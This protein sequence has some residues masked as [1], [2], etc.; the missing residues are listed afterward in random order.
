VNFIHYHHHEDYPETVLAL[1]CNQ[2]N[3][4]LVKLLLQ[5]GAN[6]EYVDQDDKKAIDST[7]SEEI[8][9]ILSF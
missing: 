5:S 9:A 8:R 2:N 1:A 4:P 7:T 3:I 6:K